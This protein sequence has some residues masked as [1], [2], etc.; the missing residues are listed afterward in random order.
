LFQY[1]KNNTLICIFSHTIFVVIK[2]RGYLAFAQCKLPALTKVIARSYF[3][4]EIAVA[5]FPGK[6]LNGP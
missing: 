5:K 2:G 3:Y 1:R 6:N 4:D